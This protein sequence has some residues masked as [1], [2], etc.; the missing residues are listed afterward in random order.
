M[1]ASSAR[2]S[3]PGWRPAADVGEAERLEQLAD[4]ALMIGDAEALG[5]QALKVNPSPAHDAMRGAVGASLDQ[6]G[7]FGLLLG[8]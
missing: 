3:C 5:D 2:A 1:N 4:R 6:I 8:R 7:E